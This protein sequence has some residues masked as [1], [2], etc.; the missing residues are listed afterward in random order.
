MFI[1]VTAVAVATALTVL[2]GPAAAQEEVALY[3]PCTDTDAVDAVI[4]LEE[5]FSGTVTTPVMPLLLNEEDAGSYML[6]LAGLEEG[7]RKRVTFTL[8]WDTPAGLGDYDMIINGTNPEEAG[9]TPEVQVFGSQAHC[10]VFD[11][12]TTAFS[13]TPADTLTLT[14][15]AS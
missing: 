1:R 7:T 2:A 8:E 13:G 3:E 10:S 14:V 4:T 11:V 9:D 15:A 6:D 12:A 5:G